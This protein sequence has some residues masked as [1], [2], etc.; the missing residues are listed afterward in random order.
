[1]DEFL[2]SP[3]TSEDQKKGLHQTWKSFFPEFKCCRP[4]SS[5]L[6]AD[7]SQTIGGNA[8]VDHSQII[9]EGLQSNYWEDIS[10]HPPR[11]SVPRAK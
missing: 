9:G 3:N 6:D 4:T 5:D 2:Y 8:N 10:P 1:M 11:V 7:Q